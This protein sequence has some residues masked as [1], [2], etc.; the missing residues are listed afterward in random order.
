MTE[1]NKLVHHLLPESTST[2]F[3]IG[4]NKTPARPLRVKPGRKV[5]ILIGGQEKEIGRN[6]ASTTKCGVLS[7]HCEVAVAK[8]DWCVAK[9]EVVVANAEAVIANAEAVIANAEAGGC[10]ESV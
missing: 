5:G 2:E 8:A 1:R 7:P 6:E 4:Q 9:A 10:E 3:Y